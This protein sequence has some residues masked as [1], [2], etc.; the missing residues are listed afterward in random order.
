MPPQ[1]VLRRTI[2]LPQDH[3]SWVFI[4]S[5]LIIGLFAG[6]SLSI[7]SLALVVAALT[8]FLIRQPITILVKTL[9]GRRPLT[10]RI[11]ALFWVIIYGAIL[12][13]ILLIFIKLNYIFIIYLALPGILVF[14]WHLYLVSKRNERGQA[15]VEIIA[16]GVLSLSAPAAYWVGM[17][18]YI[19]Y[20]WW[21]WILTWLQ[22]AAS[23]VYTYLRLAQRSLSETPSPHERLRMGSKALA[24][25]SF[26][27]I[28]TFL[29]AI[30]NVL[31]FSIFFPYFPQWIESIWGT[32]K[33]AIG[34][35]PTQIGTRQLAVSVLFTILFIFCWR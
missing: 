29:L 13:F 28:S 16:T 32:S 17:G 2:A 10:D 15:G 33:P 7:A 9:S 27:L 4:L 22:S 12:L 5:P 18:H 21:L 23:I 25:S 8:A 1:T 3:G 30:G 35:K 14:A 19:P 34:K 31:V 24:Y 26:N 11:P 20:G 6:K